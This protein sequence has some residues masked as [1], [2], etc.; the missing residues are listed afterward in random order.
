MVARVGIEQGLTVDGSLPNVRIE[1]Q[2]PLNLVGRRASAEGELLPIAEIIAVERDAIRQQLG[3]GLPAIQRGVFQLRPVLED[4]ETVA[5]LDG[6]RVGGAKL[7][8]RSEEHTS[9]LQSRQY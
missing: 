9:E 3:D 4:L 7:G 8:H 2:Q 5:E 6:V 1:V